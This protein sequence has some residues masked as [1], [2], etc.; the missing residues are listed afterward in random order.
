M[1]DNRLKSALD[2]G[3]F[4]AAPGLYD[5]ICATVAN[6]V[7]FDF[8]Y[9]SGYWL[10]ASAYGLPDAGIV[11]VT[12]LLDRVAQLCETSDAAVIADAD[13]GFGG[14][15]NV[16]HTVRAYERAGVCAIQLE[17]Q[18]FP[19]K[20]GHTPG[21]KVTPPAD[22]ID[23]IKVAVDMRETMLV[24][25]RTDA[26]QPEGY[27]AAIERA[28]AYAEAGADIIFVEALES[29]AEMASACAAIDAPML[30]N[31]ANGGVSP[32]LPTARLIELGYAMA[33]FP[34]MTSLAAAHAVESSLRHLKATGTSFAPDAPHFD[35][36]EFC[37]LIGFPDIW[38]FEQK[39]AKK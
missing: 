27:D 26:R 22:M 38:E 29:E 36:N 39:W 23:K 14:L 33:I 21:K 6:K 7:G 5:M 11:S 8:V 13:T 35:F 31:M 18:E 17:D 30:A 4:V 3:Q 1:T 24:I 2:A 9:A 28:Q 16:A 12:Q 32:I 15:L 25:A 10:T 19:K 34:A 20:C 37:E